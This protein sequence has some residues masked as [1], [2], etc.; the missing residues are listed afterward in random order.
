MSDCATPIALFFDDILKVFH[1]PHVFTL[2]THSSEPGSDTTML[3]Q[4]WKIK[5]KETELLRL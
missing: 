1:S 2:S 5:L 3:E 4:L